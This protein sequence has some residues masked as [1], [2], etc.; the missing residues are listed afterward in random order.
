[1]CDVRTCEASQMSK[2]TFSASVYRF[3]MQIVSQELDHK[4]C[5]SIFSTAL[6]RS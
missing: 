1:M 3:G 4:K 5:F 6:G 2:G